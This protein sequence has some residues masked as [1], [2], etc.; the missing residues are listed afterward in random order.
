MESTPSAA[1]AEPLPSSSP[2]PE[3]TAATPA[4]DAAITPSDATPAAAPAEPKSDNPPADSRP[5]IKLPE[6]ASL[7]EIIASIPDEVVARMSSA[8]IEALASGDLQ[9]VAKVLNLPEPAPKPQTP[10]S[11]PQAAPTPPKPDLESDEDGPTRISLRALPPKERKAVADA[12]QAV[13]EGKFNTFE[14]ARASQ[15]PKPAEAAPAEPKAEPSPEPSPKVKEIQQRIA[16]IEAKQEAAITAFDSVGLLKANRDLLDAKLELRDAEAEFKAEQSQHFSWSQQEA[17]NVTEAVKQYPEQFANPE[18]LQA[19]QDARDLA[20]H[21]Q[22]PI[23]EGSDWP[24]K[25]SE[26]VA[27][28]FKAV[29]PAPTAPPFPKPP[30]QEP[31]VRGELSSPTPP[32]TPAMSVDEALTAMDGL[33]EEQVDQ[34]LAGIKARERAGLLRR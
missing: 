33:S 19:L 28:R 26:R 14:E 32:G 10:A 5:A 23:L 29:A 22:D 11:A 6:N 24:L 7:D 12:I 20:E 30:A 15:A 27:A 4:P 34:V 21:R 9:A 17:R 3:V 31:K 18:F 8:E 13:K 16:D 1:G 2:S 25:L